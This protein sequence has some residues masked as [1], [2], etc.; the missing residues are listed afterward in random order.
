MGYDI[1][2]LNPSGNKPITP[3][4]VNS[5]PDE[6]TEYFKSRD[7]IPGHYFRNNI[8]F[9]SPLW[10]FIVEQCGDILSEADIQGGYSN[11]GHKLSK[12]KVVKIANTLDKLDEKG[13]IQKHEDEHKKMIEDAPLERCEFCEGTGR[14]NIGAPLEQDCRQCDG[15]GSTKPFSVNYPFTRENVIEFKNFLKASGGIEIC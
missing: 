14:V 5:T 9:W 8:W 1:F 12:S 6:I 15:T 11:G 13:L 2:G 3:I 4:T 7:S 10:D